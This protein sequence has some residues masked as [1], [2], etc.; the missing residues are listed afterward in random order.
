MLSRIKERRVAQAFTSLVHNPDWEIIREW[1]ESEIKEMTDR[2]IW[3][4]D[5]DQTR[6]L[7]GGSRVLGDFLKKPDQARYFLSKTK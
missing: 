2:L 5:E 1:L 6:I 4:G 3:E 7:Q